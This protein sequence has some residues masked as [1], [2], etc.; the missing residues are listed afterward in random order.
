MSMVVTNKKKGFFDVETR[1]AT[2]AAAWADDVVVVAD[3]DE[4]VV[5]N[6]AGV[7]I[8]KLFFFVTYEWD[9]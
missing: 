4:V 6:R 8:I 2:K 1:L 3:V 5:S 7:D 9:M